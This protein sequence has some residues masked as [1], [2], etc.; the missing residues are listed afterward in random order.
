MAKFV[1]L[2]FSSNRFPLLAC[3][4]FQETP[5]T[6]CKASL[7]YFSET[8]IHAAVEA[9]G[10]MAYAL[11]Y[12]APS[13]REPQ[14]LRYSPVGKAGINGPRHKHKQKYTE[15]LM[16]RIQTSDQKSRPE[17]T[18][19]RLRVPR[20]RCR[21]PVLRESIS[22]RAELGR[23]GPE[24]NDTRGRTRGQQSK[25]W[26]EFQSRREGTS[27]RKAE[28]RTFLLPAGVSVAR[29]HLGERLG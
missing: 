9:L 18:G 24:K 10:K 26:G 1:S 23:A 28:N 12:V 8:P 17:S 21:S 2:Q 7:E 11:Q 3:A 16:H 14:F 27:E 5:W 20:L 22:A 15:K 13:N 6:S 19:A 25:C 4:R 29:S